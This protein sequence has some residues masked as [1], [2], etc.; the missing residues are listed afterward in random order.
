MQQSKIKKWEM[1]KKLSFQRNK[2]RTIAVVFQHIETIAMLLLAQT[3]LVK[4]NRC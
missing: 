4:P 2:R 1:S 3:T